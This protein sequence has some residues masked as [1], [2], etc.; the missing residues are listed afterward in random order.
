M[1]QE[2]IEN[3][4]LVSLAECERKIST[5]MRR[6]I[7][8]T[9]GIG[10][11]LLKIY[12]ME[13]YKEKGYETL[14][15]YCTEEL[16]F[17]PRS[18]GRMMGIADSAKIFKDHGI[19][20]PANESQVAELTRLEPDQQPLVWERVQQL[21][22]ADERSITAQLVRDA[23]D[24]R[25]RELEQAAPATKP[26]RSAKNAL[27]EPDLDL[28]SNVSG[29]APAASSG[30]AEPP[31]RITLTEEGEAALERIRRLCGEGVADAIEHLRVLISE[32]ELKLWAE[33]DNPQD[34]THYVMNE[35][36]TVSKTIGFI[37][38]IVNERT[39]VGRL[40]TMAMAN[41]GHFE[42][43]LEGGIKITVDQLARAAA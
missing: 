39:P 31:P 27:E 28:G 29:Q 18:V 12:T 10:Q 6:G 19:E 16:Q 13:L 15:K 25:L 4:R 17:D 40:I 2:V 38:Q 42:A 32:R 20:L 37:N 11:Q 5:F 14:Y 30:P 7:E 9:V 3:P 24:Y 26:N 41:K 36:W 43:E 23:V 34:L 35:R 33:Q 8:A 21:A 1:K 22:L